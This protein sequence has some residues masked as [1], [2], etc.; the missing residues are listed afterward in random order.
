MSREVAGNAVIDASGGDG[1]AFG[2][3]GGSGGRL[4]AMLLTSFNSTNH[5]E[6]S[7]NWNGTINLKGGKGGRRDIHL[8]EIKAIINKNSTNNET[9]L[10]QEHPT[11][12]TIADLD[13]NPG[14]HDLED[15][16][17][18]QDGQDGTTK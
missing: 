14:V 9:L 4:V 6:Q 3:G 16:Q 8:P 15:L 2:G 10:M 5:I 7:I 1:S 12:P 11:R 17:V 13:V 18:A